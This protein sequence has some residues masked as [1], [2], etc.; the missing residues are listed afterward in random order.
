MSRFCRDCT[1]QNELPCAACEP[2]LTFLAWPNSRHPCIDAEEWTLT[3]A[4]VADDIS[5]FR[6]RVSGSKTRPIGQGEHHAPFKSRSGRVVIDP[7]DWTFNMPGEVF[8]RSVQLRGEV[9]RGAAWRGCFERWRGSG[10][11]IE[12]AETMAQGAIGQAARANACR[13]TVAKGPGRFGCTGHP[14]GSAM[15]LRVSASEP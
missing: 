1:L 9:E 3:L 8:E 5:S 2:A 12:R 10:P 7:A 15:Q 11:G 6:Y 14:G 13:G 4:D